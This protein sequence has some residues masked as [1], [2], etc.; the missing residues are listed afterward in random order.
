MPVLAK[1]QQSGRPCAGRMASDV[2]GFEMRLL[3]S[4]LMN[5]TV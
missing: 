4:A 3:K 5:W 1:A 2:L